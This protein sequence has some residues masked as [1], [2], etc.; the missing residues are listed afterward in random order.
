MLIIGDVHGKFSE[1]KKLLGEEP[2][3]QVGDMG[4]DYTELDCL[5]SHHKFIKGNHDNYNLHSSHDLGDYGVWQ[6]VFFIRGANSIDKNMRI[7][8]ISW[9]ADEELSYQ[10][11]KDCISMY[12]TVKPDIVVSHDCPHTTA[13]QVF[14]ITESSRTRQALDIMWGIHQPK[15][16]CFGHHHRSINTVIGHTRFICLAELETINLTIQ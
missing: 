5:S 10:E 9:W 2:S 4:F 16:W 8:G 14:G 11:L 6:N 15:I 1:Y 3:I 12:E 7:D 13:N